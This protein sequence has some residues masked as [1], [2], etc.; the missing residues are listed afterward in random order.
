MAGHLEVV[1]LL[2]ECGADVNSANPMGQTPLVHCFSRITETEQTYENQSICLKIGEV[3]LK[4]GADL[5]RLT[6]GRSL[7]MDFCG[8]KMRLSAEMLELNLSVITFLMEHGADP[9][10]KCA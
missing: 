2:A 5:N 10:L 9:Y 8:I 7:L 4:H 1:T 3:L 6:F